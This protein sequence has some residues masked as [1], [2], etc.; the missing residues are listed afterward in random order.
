VFC[1]EETGIRAF[2]W[3]SAINLG[4]FISA[5]FIWTI[6][7]TWQW[8]IGRSKLSSWLVPQLPFRLLQTRVMSAGFL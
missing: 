6:F 1:L 3:N 5:V 4:F 2:D 7:F 8:Y